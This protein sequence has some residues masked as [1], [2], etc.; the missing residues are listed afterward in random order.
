MVGVDLKGTRTL[1][2][3][4]GQGK[5]PVALVL[6]LGGREI[7]YMYVAYETMPECASAAAR[8]YVHRVARKD[9]I[10]TRNAFTSYVSLGFSLVPH[11]CSVDVDVDVRIESPQVDN[12]ILYPAGSRVRVPDH[13]EHLG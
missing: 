3:T 11:R 5:G 7:V 4:G 13:A 12:G 10:N 6:V 1:C 8:N 9:G 2:L